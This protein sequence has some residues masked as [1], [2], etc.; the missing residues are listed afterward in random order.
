MRL[1]LNRL[2]IRRQRSIAGAMK[3]ANSLNIPNLITVARILMVPLI[4]WTI[5]AGEMMVAFTLFVVA[6][7]SDAID[8]FF[9]KNFGMASALGALLDP[10]ADKV[11]L[12]SIY[13]ALGIS[14]ALPTWLV[15][16]V[17]SRDLM[18]V[19]AFILSW[20]VDKPVSVRPFMIS[21]LNTVFQIVLAGLVLAMLGLAF[22]PGWLLDVIIAIVAGL[23]FA[24]AAAYVAEWFRHMGSPEFKP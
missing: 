6:G 10:L 4:V 3:R 12:V 7:L 13:V 22:N 21:K 15:I 16:L 1:R 2:A 18:I 11:L 8:G 23:T 20:L 9:A 5:I 14:G 17:V 19:G 24:S